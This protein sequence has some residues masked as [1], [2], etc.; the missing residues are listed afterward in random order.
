MEENAVKKLIFVEGIPGSGKSTFAR[1]LANQF[2]R[3]G[4]TCDLFFETTYNHPVILS[5]SCDDYMKDNHLYIFG[6][7]KLK[8][9]SRNQFY[10]DDMSVTANFI[11]DNN[12]VNRVVITEKDLYAN[13][14]DN[15][16]A[17]VRIS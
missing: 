11:C 17:F 16:T 7:K 8:A 6:N 5:E 4:Y 12:N 2:E 14:N 10:L 3:N 9:K 13:R 15:G 1:F